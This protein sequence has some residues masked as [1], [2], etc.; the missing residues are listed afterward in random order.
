[1]GTKEEVGELLVLKGLTMV[2]KRQEP[3]DPLLRAKMRQQL[4]L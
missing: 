3:L 2:S 1:M 4:L